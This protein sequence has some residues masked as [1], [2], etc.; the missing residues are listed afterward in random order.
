[1]KLKVEVN[2]CRCHPETCCCDGY[3]VQMPYD[4]RI[5]FFSRERAERFVKWVEEQE[6]I[7]EN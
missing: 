1:M 5:P 2:N 4:D 3:Y 7:D 6:L